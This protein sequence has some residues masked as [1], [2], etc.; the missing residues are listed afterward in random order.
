MAIPKGPGVNKRQSLA[1]AI[2]TLE[3]LGCEPMAEIVEALYY[4]KNKTLA[5]GNVDDNGRSDQ[6]QFLA[7][8]IK[9]AET[10]AKFKYPTLSA[11][12]VK[13]LQGGGNDQKVITTEQAINVIKADPFAP[14]SVKEIS[15]ERVIEAL[16]NS[17]ITPK[18]PE[19]YK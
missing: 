19:G 9:S 17:N 4:A 6:A 14:Q 11:I 10:L 12:A 15:T 18:L 2:T 7:L 16:E 8:W 5:G 3:R 13:D 1:L